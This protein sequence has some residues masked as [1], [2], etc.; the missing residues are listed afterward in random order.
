MEMQTTSAEA[1]YNTL[2][3]LKISWILRIERI[4]HCQIQNEQYNVVFVP[5]KIDHDSITDTSCHIKILSEVFLAI[6]ITKY[7][8]SR[9]CSYKL[10]PF[11]PLQ[12][13][14]GLKIRE[15]IDLPSINKMT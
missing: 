6:K 5:S 8:P 15:Q 1:R 12:L 2:A 10:P 4:S 13:Y 9:P 14:L 11:S 3:A 7:P